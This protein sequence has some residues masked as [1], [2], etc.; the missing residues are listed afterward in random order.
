MASSP[1][2][3]LPAT[4]TLNPN[5]M[6]GH[7]SPNLPQHDQP[8]SSPQS[9][10]P[11]E[12]VTP[13]NP[14]SSPGAVP[15]DKRKREESDTTDLS[16]HPLHKTSLCSYFRRQAGSCSHGDT[17]RYAHG[18]E[19]LRQRPDNTWDPTSERAKKALKLENRGDQCDEKGEMEVMMMDVVVDGDGHGERGGENHSECFLDPG[20]SKCLVHLPMK[21]DSERLRKF[22]TEQGVPFK[23]AKKKKGMAVGFVSFGDTEQLKSAM[24]EL[25][26]KSV[27]N[28]NIKVADVVPRSF[29]KD[30]KSAIAPSENA[31]EASEAISAGENVGT[32]MWSDGIEVADA[33]ND[34]SA[35]DASV[36][37]T[38]SVRDAVTPLAHMPYGD[39]LEHKK[40]S[41]M[42]MLK[43]LTRN[44]RKAC[45]TGVPIPEWILKAREIGGLPCE[46][47]GILESP[48]LNGYRNKCEFSVGYSLQGKPTV[49]FMLG[50]FREAV[51][52]VEEPLN[53]PNVS[54]I[55]CKYALV[56]Q[57]FL[58]HSGFPVWNRFKNT[59]FW[60]Q[61]T[62]REGRSPGKTTDVEKEIVSEVM[63]IVQVC[64]VGYDDALITNEFESLAQAFAV[65]AAADTLP[66]KV[67]VVQDHQGI[68]N[69][70]PANAPLRPLPVPKVD[71]NSNLEAMDDAEEMRIHDCI[72]NL[73]FSIS[74]TAFFQ[75]NTLAAEKLYSLAGDW[76]GLGPDSLLFDVC[77]GTGT[78]GLTLAHRVGMV[79]GIEMNAAAVQDACRNAEINGIT[80]C[81]FVCG[82]AEDVMGSILKEYLN[83][84]N[85]PDEQ[86]NASETIPDEKDTSVNDVQNSEL[87]SV[88]GTDIGEVAPGCSANGEQEL[89]SCSQKSCTSG[90]GESLVPQFKDVVA[91]VDPPR[92]G[93]HPTT[94]GAYAGNQNSANEST[95]TEASIH[96]MQS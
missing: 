83:A 89:Q 63:L 22:L 70:A 2:N 16:L 60:R 4:E 62:V 82:K 19:E 18:E 74:P 94:C 72:S 24:E 29:E 43:K 73:K 90:E 64:S 5:S 55:A 45:P 56:F 12:Q 81:R 40:N 49:G 37:R 96:I 91:I 32:A 14:Q 44:A 36:P 27:G 42:Q 10:N 93:L 38:R 3:G 13:P 88:L 51:T 8:P 20:L 79:I 80:N 35:S 23:S 57:K 75:V 58:Q 65:G 17:C 85:K 33:N 61:L 87:C 31:P 30:L 84:P 66:L 52:A 21:W 59:G 7:Y 78:I 34:G 9:N 67:L 11:K 54:T 76:A 86:L 92:V 95:T 28:K 15:G 41:V 6:N 1:H 26:G 77:C 48:V 69:V 53:C 50:S 47:V 39:Q 25:D 68:S 46:L 71:C